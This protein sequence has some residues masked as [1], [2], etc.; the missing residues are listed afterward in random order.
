MP[1]YGHRSNSPLSRSGIPQ[2]PAWH[3]R[4]T[5]QS[6]GLKHTPSWHEHP[7]GLPD[8]PGWNPMPH[9]SL[10]DYPDDFLF[11]SMPSQIILPSAF[12]HPTCFVC[13]PSDGIFQYPVK[14]RPLLYMSDVLDRRLKLQVAGLDSLFLRLSQNSNFTQLFR[15]I[16]E[17]AVPDYWSGDQFV[18]QQLLLPGITKLVLQAGRIPYGYSLLVSCGCLQCLSSVDLQKVE[19]SEKNVKIKEN[20]TTFAFHYASTSRTLR[21]SKGRGLRACLLSF[22]RQTHVKPLL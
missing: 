9:V 20:N 8:L 22:R 17:Y 5:Y 6:V 14:E 21:G 11:Y 4:A 7:T 2:L 3:T 15:N 18:G 1:C 10:L 12:C 16:H 19:R 13:I